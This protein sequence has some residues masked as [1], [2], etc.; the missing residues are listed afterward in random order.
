MLQCTCA[1]IALLLT[2]LQFPIVI[3]KA[4]GKGQAV[5]CAP[6]RHVR[7]RSMAPQ[8]LNQN[9]RWICADSWRPR[10]PYSE[11]RTHDT[12]WVGGMVG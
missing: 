9:T 10:P 2:M 8:V 11:D 12:H 7:S 5:F 1:K 6:R 4:T 3:Y